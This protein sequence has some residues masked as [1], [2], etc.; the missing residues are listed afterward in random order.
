MDKLTDAKIEANTHIPAALKAKLEAYADAKD[1]K[2]H[3]WLEAH[4]VPAASLEELHMEKLK[5]FLQSIKDKATTH[6]YTH[7]QVEFLEAAAD[8]LDKAADAKIEA[9]TKLSAAMKTKLEAIADA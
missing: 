3:A 2:L 1:A 8:K 9:N 6:Q 4:E 7:A 5:N